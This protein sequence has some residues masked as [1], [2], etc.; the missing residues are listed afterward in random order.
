MMSVVE[1]LNAIE[2]NFREPDKVLLNVASLRRALFDLGVIPAT[3]PELE[4]EA[5]R[6]VIEEGELVR[7]DFCQDIA[8]MLIN[9]VAMCQRCGDA[10]MDLQYPGGWNKNLSA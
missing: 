5:A 4:A 3:L 9:F 8:V 6:Y 10:D 2:R 1:A 7:C